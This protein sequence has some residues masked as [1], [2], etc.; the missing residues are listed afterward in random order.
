M[1]PGAEPR[2]P[3]SSGPHFGG[4]GTARV[5]RRWFVA[6]PTGAGGWQGPGRHGY[7]YRAARDGI[8]LSV[9]GQTTCVLQGRMLFFSAPRAAARGYS[10][11]HLEPWEVLG[12]FS[13]SR[14]RRRSRS[15][16]RDRLRHRREFCRQ[17]ADI[18]H[19]VKGGYLRKFGTEVGWLSTGA[20][21]DAFFGINYYCGHRAR[22]PEPPLRVRA[23]LTSTRALEHADRFSLRVEVVRGLGPLEMGS[24][25]NHVSC[26]FAKRRVA[27]FT[28]AAESPHPGGPASRPARISL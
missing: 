1:E 11:G 21:Q 26:R 14:T 5:I 20:L 27:C 16:L 4:R 10:F 17:G 9:C 19:H 7:H 23:G 22:V 18:R 15:P 6:P 25:R 13:C 2:S 8:P 3:D 24:L 28:P 12:A